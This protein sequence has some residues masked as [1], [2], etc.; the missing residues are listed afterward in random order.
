MCV[1]RCVHKTYVGCMHTCMHTEPTRTS[2]CMSVH[3]CMNTGLYVLP[4][5]CEVYTSVH[6]HVWTPQRVY[7]CKHTHSPWRFS[8]HEHP[9]HRSVSRCACMCAQRAHREEDF[10][11]QAGDLGML[12]SLLILPPVEQSDHSLP[13]ACLFPLKVPGILPF[14]WD[15]SLPDSKQSR[16]AGATNTWNCDATPTR[17]PVVPHLLLRG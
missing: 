1:Y 10:S 4:V 16:H 17:A 6:M 12:P 9:T 11:D 7:T 8:V 5:T 14:R 15:H 2:M 13:L 3:A